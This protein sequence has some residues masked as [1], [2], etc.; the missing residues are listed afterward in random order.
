MSYIPSQSSPFFCFYSNSNQVLVPTSNTT[1]Y[2][3]DSTDYALNQKLNISNKIGAGEIINN[4]DF[5]LHSNSH[6][7]SDVRTSNARSS[8]LY[9]RCNSTN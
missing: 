1:I 7:M 9:S 6:V 2:S 3:N 8:F 5:V 4:T